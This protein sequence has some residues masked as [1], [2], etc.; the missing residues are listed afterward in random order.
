MH[1]YTTQKPS[2][3]FPN[4]KALTNNDNL[5]NNDNDMILDNKEQERYNL[6]ALW[7]IGKYLIS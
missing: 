3:I 5:N 7:N 6:Q 2:N 1:T 4:T